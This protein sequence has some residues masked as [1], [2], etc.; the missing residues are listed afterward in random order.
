MK[1]FEQRWKK[2]Q[3]DLVH[4]LVNVEGKYDFVNRPIVENCLGADYI[5]VTEEEIKQPDS[6]N[7]QFFRSVDH[8]SAAAV[9]GN[10]MCHVALTPRC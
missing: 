8:T 5:S 3:P 10:S 2:Q 9:E 7:V 1:N 4:L 6:W